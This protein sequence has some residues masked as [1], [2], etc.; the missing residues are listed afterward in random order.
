MSTKAR[1]R[2]NGFRIRPISY[3][4]TPDFRDFP[5]AAFF[6]IGATGVLSVGLTL[7]VMNSLGE[8]G[9]AFANLGNASGTI[10]TTAPS[11]HLI[12]KGGD[13]TRLHPNAAVTGGAANG[14]FFWRAMDVDAAAAN[15]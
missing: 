13:I 14:L 9:L 6:E 8:P 1:G 10:S 15:A 2:P 4:S 5:L 3:A 11:W 7:V 12:V